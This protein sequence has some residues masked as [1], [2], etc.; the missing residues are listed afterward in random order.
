MNK[1]SVISILNKSFYLADHVYSYDSAFFP[2]CGKTTRAIVDKKKL[3]DKDYI[4]AYPKKNEWIISDS[5]Y[6][7]SKLLLS[8]DWCESMVPKM[9]KKEH[10]DTIEN[11]YDIPPVPSK[12]ELQDHEKF[13]DSDGNILDIEVV[14]ERSYDKCYFRVKDI[15]TTFDIP[16]I[17]IRIRDSESGYELNIHYKVFTNQNERNPEKLTSKKP[18]NQNERNPLKLT[19]KK[20]FYL[21]YRGLIRLL[22]VSRS[23]NAE[24]F[25]DWATEKLFTIQMGTHEQKQILS[26]K[27]LGAST[28]EVKNVLKS[29]VKSISCI[30][31]FTLGHVK[32]L[33][34]VFDIPNEYNDNS[35]VAKYG[36]TEDLV[37]RT[38]EHE[39]DL[40]KIEGV[41]LRLK[42]YSHIDKKYASD[43]E[44][45][46][47][48]F[49][50]NSFMDLKHKKREELVIISKEKMIEVEK[51]FNKIRKCYAGDY[52]EIIAEKDKYINEINILKLKQEMILREIEMQKELRIKDEINHQKD[53]ENYKLKLELLQLKLDTKN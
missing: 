19:S 3:A 28:D 37:R 1:P 13:Q 26:N 27:L 4:F 51:E 53:I 23:K 43:A 48:H 33:R 24:S 18:T 21:T 45:D 9:I 52:L 46:L 8:S 12:L 30:Y 38:N 15:I 5:K 17:D 49:M 47:K 35:I 10:Y 20:E 2:G 29:Y 16:N 42:I 25:Q 36:R 31:L 6:A 32:D 14:G 50:Q 39:S 40:G 41:Q 11:L 22:Y 44:N 34:N 7:R